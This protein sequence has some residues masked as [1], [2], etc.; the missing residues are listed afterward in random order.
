[1]K[2]IFS[3]YVHFVSTPPLPPVRKHT[4]LTRHPPPPLVRT[5]YVDGPKEDGAQQSPSLAFTLIGIALD[6]APPTR[7]GPQRQRGTRYLSSE[8][9]FYS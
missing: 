7:I 4:L 8:F 9:F 6:T 3:A 1:M 2:I 5:Y